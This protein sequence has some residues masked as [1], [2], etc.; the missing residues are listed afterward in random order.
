[1]E[2]T[3]KGPNIRAIGIPEGKEVEHEDKKYL[4][5]RSLQAPAEDVLYLDVHVLVFTFTDYVPHRAKPTP[6]LILPLPSSI[7]L[8]Q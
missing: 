2:D 1:M 7:K 5:S 6:P 4:K 8:N 3:D